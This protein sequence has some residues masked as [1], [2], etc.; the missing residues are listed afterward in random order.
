M[1]LGN[2]DHRYLIWSDYPAAGPFIPQGHQGFRKGFE[3]YQRAGGGYIT[4]IEAIEMLDSPTGTLINDDAKNQLRAR[5][6]T[7]LVDQRRLG[8]R[9]PM[10]TRELVTEAMSKSPLP[11]HER[12]ERLLR[13]LA[14]RS[15]TVGHYVSLYRDGVD[16][17]VLSNSFGE[18]IV[19]PFP[20]NPVLQEAMA[21]SE[22]TTFEEVMYLV[23]YLTEKSWIREQYPRSVNFQVTVD[24]HG[25]IADLNANPSSLQAFMAMWINDETERAFTEG[26]KR[27]IEDAGYQVLR[28]DKKEDV[29]K[30]DDEIISEIRRS[31]FLV[32]DFTQGNDGARGGVYFEAGFALGLG[33]PVIFTCRTDM[34]DK[35]HFDTRQYAHILW[36]EPENLR[37]DI[38]DRIRARL[39]QG[40][41]DNSTRP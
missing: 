27:G 20:T 12:A 28:I 35:L 9:F 3:R 16:G 19:Q 31:R 13:Y 8:I 29:V 18:P 21:W 37:V 25:R 7:M 24:G 39:G 10:V 38:R 14:L 34:V 40:P 4:S 26:L 33:I 23:Q 17:D 2:T 11:V 1:T 36:D 22:S 15:G 41:G 30:I 5:L 6:T 32:A